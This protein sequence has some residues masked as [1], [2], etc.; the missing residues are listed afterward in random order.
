MGQSA[1]QPIMV[2]NQVFHLAGPGLWTL[3][4]PGQARDPNHW[5]VDLADTVN[6]GPPPVDP[7]DIRISHS[8]PTYSPDSQRLYFGTSHGYIWGVSAQPGGKAIPWRLDEGCQ[9][10]SSPLV[11]RFDN[12]EFVVV[13]V[14][15]VGNG[16]SLAEGKVYAIWG[17]DGVGSP[18]SVAYPMGGWPTP[19]AV[20]G[21]VPGEFIMGADGTGDPGVCNGKVQKLRLEQDLAPGSYKVTPVDWK[22]SACVPVGVADGFA[23][24]YGYVYWLDK[25]GNLYARGF[26][27]ATAPAAWRT[28]PGWHAEGYISLTEA[29]GGGLAFTNTVPAIDAQ[30]VNGT[31]QGSLYITL[32]NYAAL[33]EAGAA[34]RTILENSCP[35]GS[36]CT[37]V[38]GAIVAVDIASGAIR[39]SD[40]LPA[41]DPGNSGLL[42]S[43][44]TSPLVLKSQCRVVFGDVQ[45]YLNSYLLKNQ[46]SAQRM[47]LTTSDSG[48]IS[49]L[50]A[51][52]KPNLGPASFSQEA[53]AGTEP[54]VASGSLGNNANWTQFL[55]GVNYRKADGTPG[56][57]LMAIPMGATYDLRWDGPGK[58]TETL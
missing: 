13:G 43:A 12:R 18:G 6:A 55:M 46:G 10:V 27:D 30:K 8:T 56:G 25:W 35:S 19:S 34:D 1:T 21:L 5:P 51:G 58:A 28:A 54:S 40:R 42:R 22:K 52:E 29:L 26:A 49:L 36:G 14:K 57:R 17:L 44:N 31:V 50:R 45:G 16:C 4:W 23:V 41:G 38:R 37:G 47:P 2:G 15:P 33:G 32:R 24:S 9:I 53:G 7:N 39:W 48:E 20:P 11:L 3:Q